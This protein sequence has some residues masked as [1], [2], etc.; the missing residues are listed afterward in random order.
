MITIGA[1]LVKDNKIYE[2]IEMGTWGFKLVSKTGENLVYSNVEM[3]IELEEGN[4]Q[5]LISLMKYTLDDLKQR[6]L[7]GESGLY[8][9]I[10]EEGQDVIVEMNNYCLEIDTF[11]DNGWIRKNVYEWD[12]SFWIRSEI[13]EGKWK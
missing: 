12:G 3:N 10:N 2:V 5:E 9:S 7:N 4:I 11:Q 1:K 8:T 13:Y 6:T